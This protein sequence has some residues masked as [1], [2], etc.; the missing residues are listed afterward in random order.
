MWLMGRGA[1]AKDAGASEA[2]DGWAVT[3]CV[4]MW[5]M[6][7]ALGCAGSQKP[8]GEREGGAGYACWAEA[9]GGG[10][11]SCGRGVGSG[12]VGRLAADGADGGREMLA[13]G[14]GADGVST[15]T[16]TAGAVEGELAQVV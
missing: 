16:G 8:G 9:L 12:G 1:G 11:R 2:T 6:V 4:P 7:G 3:S 10:G 14:L 15:G 13:V 5:N